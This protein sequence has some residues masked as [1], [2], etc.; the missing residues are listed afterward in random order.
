VTGSITFWNRI[1]PRV[2][3]DS[4]DRA[5]AA[6]VRDPLWLLTRQWQFGELRGEDAGSIAFTTVARTTSTFSAW[7]APDGV[8]HPIDGPVDPAALTEGFAPDYAVALDL[9]ALLAELAAEAAV[10]GLPAALLAH[11]F[12]MPAPTA[13]D[14]TSDAELAARADHDAQRFLGV[15]GGRAVDGVAVLAAAETDPA[16]LAGS[17]GLDAADAAAA[18]SALREFVTEARATFGALA[19]DDPV[20]WDA[21]RLRSSMTLEA[22]HPDGGAVRFD[23]TPNDDGAV[24][25]YA[26]DLD[27]G[28]TGAGGTGGGTEERASVLP[29][30][31]LFR[32]MPRPRW[33]QFEDG[34]MD[35]GAIQPDR[36][37]LATLLVM[38]FLLVHGNDW[39]VIPA[40]QPVGTITRV[41]ALLV[42]DVFGDTYQ[43]EAVDPGAGWG[44]FGTGSREARWHVLPPSLAAG[45]LHGAPV[46]EVHFV[47]D[48]SANMAWGV[49]AILGG[50]A[51]AALRG[52]ERSTALRSLYASSSTGTTSG[53][54]LTYRIGGTVPDHWIPLLPVADAARVEE[55]AL[56]RGAM[57]RTRDDGTETQIEPAGRVLASPATPY[58]IREEEVPTE[59]VRVRRRVRFARWTDGSTYLWVSRARESGATQRNPGLQFDRAVTADGG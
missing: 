19:S 21:T 44:V 51:G 2:R 50:G 15:V 6:Q 27:A 56:E 13:G 28:A 11:G 57:V 37:D 22:T 30:P 31:V 59:G 38:D 8:A 9:A 3:T 18:E 16:A 1:E 39:F 35:V 49:E 20:T 5:L 25:W 7:A 45:G 46:E 43:V 10:P 4:L 33:W 36:R 53:G 40:P 24:P 54:G 12:A 32:G 29:L 42:R 58:R 34:R 48:E 55:V 17:L 47:R 14:A 41:D 26:L 23:V 52:D